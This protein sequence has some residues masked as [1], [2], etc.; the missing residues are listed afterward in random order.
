M[1][2]DCRRLPGVCPRKPPFGGKHPHRNQKLVWRVTRATRSVREM[3]EHD[4][5][6]PQLLQRLHKGPRGGAGA[7]DKELVARASDR[8]RLR[9][10]TRRSRVHSRLD[11][12]T[13]RITVLSSVPF[14]ASG[15]E[16][17]SGVRGR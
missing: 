17:S 4:P 5:G 15:P 10:E 6:A 12:H 8:D 11:T 3:H 7:A 14:A 2:A 16:R 13:R 9:G 1:R